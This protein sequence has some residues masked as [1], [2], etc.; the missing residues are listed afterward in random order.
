MQKYVYVSS[1]MRRQDPI[2]R[3]MGYG[4]PVWH[5]AGIVKQALTLDAT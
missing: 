4:T 1:G 3:A 2:P 5:K